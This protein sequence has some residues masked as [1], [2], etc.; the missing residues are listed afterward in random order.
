[1]GTAVATILFYVL[2]KRAGG[3]FASMVTYG[4]PFIALSWGL[5][6]GEL[7][8]WWQVVGLVIILVGVYVTTRKKQK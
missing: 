4:I 8:N 1:M 6:A 7:I 2:I 5:L 3:L